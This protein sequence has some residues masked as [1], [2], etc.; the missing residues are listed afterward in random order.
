MKIIRHQSLLLKENVLLLRTEASIMN[1]LILWFTFLILI[2]STGCSVFRSRVSKEDDNRALSHFL[3]SNPFENIYPRTECLSG[4]GK[5][6]IEL[7]NQKIQFSS[8]SLLQTEEF[9]MGLNSILF[10]ELELNFKLNSGLNNINIDDQPLWKS[11]FYELLLREFQKNEPTEKGKIQVKKQL[12]YLLKKFLPGFLYYLKMRQAHSTPEVALHR[13]EFIPIGEKKPWNEV[14]IEGPAAIFLYPMQSDERGDWGFSI[15][16][17][18]LKSPE[19]SIQQ[20]EFDVRFHQYEMELQH[21]QK[22]LMKI[23]LIQKQCAL[24]N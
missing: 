11:R 15:V 10:G 9:L 1:T 19:S 22:N 17:S 13:L 14:I 18:Q 5:I 21:N 4:D 6:Q 7:H 16:E 12:S 23:T 3:S 20:K 8:E 2:L 24:M